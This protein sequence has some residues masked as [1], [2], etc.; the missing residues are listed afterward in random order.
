MSNVESLLRLNA[1][2][3]AFSRPLESRQSIRQMNPLQSILNPRMIFRCDTFRLIKAANRY[4]NFV[5]FRSRQKCERRSAMRTERTETP[6]PRKLA[7]LTSRKSKAVSAKRR[8][9]D[10][11]RSTAAPAIGTMAVREVVRFAPGFVAH[12]STQTTPRDDSGFHF[13]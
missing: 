6:G 12:Q 4:I 7:R 10:E 3:S 8:P 5:G 11:R 2:A 13:S 1:Y 9:G